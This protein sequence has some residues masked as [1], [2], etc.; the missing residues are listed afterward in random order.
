MYSSK[1]LKFLLNNKKLMLML[2]SLLSFYL[3]TKTHISF[4]KYMGNAGLCSVIFIIFDNEILRGSLILIIAYNIYKV[5]S[6]F[7]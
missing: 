4:L 6:Y 7:F 1:M 2:F 5:L 3:Y